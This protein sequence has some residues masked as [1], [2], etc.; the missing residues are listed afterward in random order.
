MRRFAAAPMK[1]IESNKLNP[2]VRQLPDSLS[3]IMLKTSHRTCQHTNT[4]S[5]T[6][7]GRLPLMSHQ[8]EASS[9][10]QLRSGTSFAGKFSTF[11]VGALPYCSIAPSLREIASHSNAPTTV[12]ASSTLPS[13]TAS[14][15]SGSST[16]STLMNSS[17]SGSDCSKC[18]PVAM[19]R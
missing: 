3:P 17:L 15:S 4:Y 9:L 13:R 19:Y 1:A 14:I 16:R 10:R 12:F 11:A 7:R 18:R 6:R 5:V 8:R 2:S